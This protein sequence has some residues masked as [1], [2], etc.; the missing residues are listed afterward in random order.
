[1]SDFEVSVREYLER[2]GNFAKP[3]SGLAHTLKEFSSNIENRI[4]ENP[5]EAAGIGAALGFL[6]VKTL[7]SG[8]PF[9]ARSLGKGIGSMLVVAF[10]E[11]FSSPTPAKERGLPH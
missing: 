7:K 11:S 9:L 8:S 1:M 10:L 5:L 6:F 4:R 3:I 2:V